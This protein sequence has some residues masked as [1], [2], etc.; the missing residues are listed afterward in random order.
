MLNLSLPKLL[1]LLM[2]KGINKSLNDR[3]TIEEYNSMRDKFSELLRA[4]QQLDQGA[5]K[6]QKR[7]RPHESL[8]GHDRSGV[9]GKILT[10][11][12][13]KVIYIRKK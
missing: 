2:Q 3:L 12:L 11:G 1:A 7:N 6:F 4:V 10:Y 9:Y 5:F 8:V 13:G